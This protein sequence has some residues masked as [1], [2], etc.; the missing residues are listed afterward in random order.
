MQ[1]RDVR[2]EMRKENEKNFVLQNFSGEGREVVFDNFRN[3]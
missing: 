3:I 1:E 2:M